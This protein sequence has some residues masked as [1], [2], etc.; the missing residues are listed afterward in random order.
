MAF[1]HHRWDM[2][3]FSEVIQWAG[4]AHE[5]C[6]WARECAFPS[7]CSRIIGGF[8]RQAGEVGGGAGLI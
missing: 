7:H 4:C 6:Q 2:E 5:A 1:Y 3:E 8:L